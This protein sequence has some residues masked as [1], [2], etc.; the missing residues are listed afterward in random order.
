MKFGA[1]SFGLPA[2]LLAASLF[3]ACSNTARG[4][5]EDTAQNADAARDASQRAAEDTRNATDRAADA[6]RDA[7]HDTAVGTRG[8]SDEVENKSKGAASSTAS[9]LDAAA[10]TAEIKTALM[11]DDSVDAGGIDVDSN[12][13]T[14]TV[15]LKGHVPTAAQKRTAERIAKTKA[16]DYKIVNDLRVAA[17]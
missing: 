8:M 15:T 5:K 13:A 1:K 14:K 6:T 4:V 12:G 9:G 11:A 10:Q 3:G 7:A 2:A 16:P 17:K